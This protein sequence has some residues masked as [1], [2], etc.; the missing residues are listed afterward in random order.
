[1]ETTYATMVGSICLDKAKN[2]DGEPAPIRFY[3][4][5]VINGQ[6]PWM[7]GRGN[8]RLSNDCETLQ[9]AVRE[10]HSK[11]LL[12]I[13]NLESKGDDSWKFDGLPDD[14]A[15]WVERGLTS[16]DYDNYKVLIVTSNG[17]VVY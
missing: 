9:D 2:E 7:Q 3:V 12:H 5:K 10:L 17:D 6:Q 14:I 4:Q 11:Y 1:M 15:Y 13:S 8:M 16:F